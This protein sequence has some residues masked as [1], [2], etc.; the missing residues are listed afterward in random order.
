MNTVNLAVH[1]EV[2][3]RCWNMD[4]TR[5]VI[6]FLIF[7]KFTLAFLR[8]LIV[9]IYNKTN[10]IRFNLWPHSLFAIV[11]LKTFPWPSTFTSIPYAFISTVK[12]SLL[13]DII[14]FPQYFLVKGSIFLI[15][16]FKWRKKT[17]FTRWA[18]TPPPH[19][20]NNLTLYTPLKSWRYVLTASHWSFTVIRYKQTDGN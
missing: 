20:F 9:Y 3:V 11:P 14:N 12:D 10:A 17:R 6:I 5:L 16:S 8:M 2:P 4:E 1:N 18:T 19:P 13:N 15:S 7:A